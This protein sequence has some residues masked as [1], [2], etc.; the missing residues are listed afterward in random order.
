M[1]FDMDPRDE[2][3]DPVKAADGMEEVGPELPSQSALNDPRLF[4]PHPAQYKVVSRRGS[5]ATVKNQGSGKLVE[6]DLSNPIGRQAL[7]D[8][9]RW[10]KIGAERRKKGVGV[11]MG[12]AIPSTLADSEPSPRDASAS[13]RSSPAPA[14]PDPA[15]PGTDSLASS[16]PCLEP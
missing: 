11:K 15:S 14:C 10:R 7:A 3:F 13:E 6:L 16:G 9:E 2:E 12:L 5:R 8:I 4:I 1:S